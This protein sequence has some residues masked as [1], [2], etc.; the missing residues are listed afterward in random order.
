MACEDVA[1]ELKT[2]AVTARWPRMRRPGETAPAAG[3][4]GRLARALP[5]AP[6]RKRRPGAPLPAR[7]GTARSSFPRRAQGRSWPRAWRL[8]GPSHPGRIQHRGQV[9]A[10]T[11]R[12]ADRGAGV[13]PGSCPVIAATAMGMSVPVK[14]RTGHPARESAGGDADGGGRNCGVELGAVSFRNSR[15]VSLALGN[16]GHCLNGPLSCAW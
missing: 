1:R 5:T 10:G 6:V 8:R 4:P 16:P 9:Q 7:R 12:C 11:G 3:T 15:S 2:A 13:A 14:V